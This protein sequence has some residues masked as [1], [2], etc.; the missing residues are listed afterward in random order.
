MR[1]IYGQAGH[2]VIWLGPSSDDSELALQEIRLAAERRGK[3]EH[4]QSGRGVMERVG[5]FTDDS[6][7]E[8]DDEGVVEPEQVQIKL[9]LERR[10]ISTAVW[11]LLRRAWFR[12]VWILQEIYAARST[13]VMCGSAKVP[14]YTFC[15]GVETLI[16][17]DIECPRTHTL[18]RSVI[19]LMADTILQPKYETRSPGTVSIGELIDMYHSHEAT[20]RH[21]KIY[22]LLGMSADDDGSQLDKAGLLPNYEVP[23]HTLLARFVT[24]LFP[25]RSSLQ[26]FPGT[27][28]TVF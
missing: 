16:N 22:A 1:T 10:R 23:W 15:L 3:E 5:A 8:G 27:D 24:Y 18:V 17:S 11:R 7:Q 6:V 21:D 26:T 2:V 9:S 28:I 12:R 25:G 20:K 14:S 4:S 19:S 13:I